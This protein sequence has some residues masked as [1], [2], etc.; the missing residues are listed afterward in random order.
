M[1]LDTEF[2]ELKIE[3]SKVGGLITL[4]TCMKELRVPRKQAIQHLSEYC[5]REQGDTYFFFDESIHVLGTDE[6]DFT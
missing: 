2:N 5:Q 4:A 6:F 1:K 3:A